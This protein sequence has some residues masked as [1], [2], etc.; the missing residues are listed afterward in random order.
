MMYGGR[1]NLLQHHY[2]WKCMQVGTQCVV[3]RCKAHDHVHASLNAP[4]P[5]L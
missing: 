4:M 3:A 5:K 1:N 2:L